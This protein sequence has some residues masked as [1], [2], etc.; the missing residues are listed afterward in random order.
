VEELGF[1]PLVHLVHD[2]L[3]AEFDDTKKGRQQAEL[4]GK[5]MVGVAEEIHPGVPGKIELGIGNS[6]SDKA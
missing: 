6:W 1:N 4:M 3:V 2:E 5:I